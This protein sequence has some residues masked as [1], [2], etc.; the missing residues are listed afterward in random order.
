MTLQEKIDKAAVP[1]ILTL[2]LQGEP[3]LLDLRH[4][5]ADMP[6][7]QADDHLIPG[8]TQVTVST[9]KSVKIFL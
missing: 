4:P 7:D 3:N 5:D 1:V 8:D 6:L 2:G 9:P